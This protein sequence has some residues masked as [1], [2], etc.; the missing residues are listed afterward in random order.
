[1][2]QQG[3]AYFA[4]VAELLYGDIATF[5]SVHPITLDSVLSDPEAL[6]GLRVQDGLIWTTQRVDCVNVA[7]R[8]VLGGPEGFAAIWIESD[9]RLTVT[10]PIGGQRVCRPLSHVAKVHNPVDAAQA[11]GLLVHLES[12]ADDASSTTNIRT[13]AYFRGRKLQKEI[14][15]T[16][17]DRPDSHVIKNPRPQGGRLCIRSDD[18]VGATHHAA[19]T[20]VLDC[21]GSMGTRRGETFG[22]DTK[23]AQAVSAVEELLDDL[24]TGVRLS[25]WT[26]GQAVGPQKTAVPA[27]GSIRRVQDPIVWNANDPSQKENLLR[28]IRYPVVEPWNES[29]LL[30]AMIA[31]STDLKDIDGVRSLVV[32]T[33]GADNRV[34]TDAVTN[35]LGLTTEALIKQ[36]FNGTGIT[37][38]VVGFKVDDSE[39]AKTQR[40]LAVVEQLLPPGRFVFADQSQQLSE[41]IRGLLTV[42]PLRKYRTLHPR[43]G[44]ESARRWTLPISSGETPGNWT[45]LLPSGL[46]RVKASQQATASLIQIDDGDQLTLEQTA[47]GLLQLWPTM[48]RHWPWASRRNSGRWTVALAEQPISSQ[49]ALSRRLMFWA[50]ANGGAMSIQRPA[51]LWIE[52]F[53]EDQS[54]AVGCQ[55][56]NDATCETYDL[57]ISN[58]SNA[59]LSC[60]IWFSEQP[61]APVGTLIRDQD[62]VHLNDLAPAS[63]QLSEGAVYLKSAAI[64]THHV[65]DAT[66]RITAQPCLVLRGSG[67]VGVPLRLRTVGLKIE[68]EDEQCFSELGQFTLRQWPVTQ[69]QAERSLQGVQLIS[70]AQF[71]LNCERVGAKVVFNNEDD[72]KQLRTTRTHELLQDLEMSLHAGR[73]R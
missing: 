33:D 68:G 10:Q 22:P 4:R 31:A 59:K 72:A 73:Q 24:P 53:N 30:A 6:I 35:P 49:Q 38:N 36:R 55:R 58:A 16:V 17:A 57:T 51:D 14:P 64:E 61:A 46:Y 13:Y 39:K 5:N 7:V 25:V 63:W 37:V 62:F 11:D 27:E 54:L 45:P 32:V 70:I 34:A 66:G 48:Q 42:H 52:A 50:P 29:P 47:T 20:L 21:S 65:A 8:T 41:A 26:F 40:Q 1:M 18:P 9:G 60:N 19:M 43:D 12:K 2:Q 71:K 67:P 15:V 69:E 3:P 23:Y 28:A 44:S 56:R